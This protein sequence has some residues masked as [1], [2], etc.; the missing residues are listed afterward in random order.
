[1]KRLLYSALGLA[2]LVAL[3]WVLF[4]SATLR[5]RLTLEAEV[6]GKP[7]AGSGVIEVTSALSPAVMTNASGPYAA[8]VIVRGQAVALDLADRGTL[9]ALLKDNGRAGSRSGSDEL[10]GGH[11]ALSHPARPPFDYHEV[12]RLRGLRLKTE[13]P[14]SRLP[15]LV[16]FRDVDDPKTVERVDPN[17][18]AAS[19]GPGVR[20]VRATVEIVPAG[21]WPF[22]ALGWPGALAGVPV[23]V[24]IETKLGWLAELRGGYLHGGST[25]RNAPFGLHGGDFQRK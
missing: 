21:W 16:R 18:L 24:G 13:L 17:D 20:L 25:S 5:Y 19:F 14:F 15:L 8:Q 23:T 1:M 3:W 4:P 9:F 10:F 22:N 12:K 6:D 11:D 7:V 2:A